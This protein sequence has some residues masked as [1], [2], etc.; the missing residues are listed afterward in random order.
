MSAGDIGCNTMRSK[1]I[2]VGGALFYFCT[3]EDFKPKGLMND[4]FFQL[5]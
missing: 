1:H 4:F 5:F 3:C 2:K